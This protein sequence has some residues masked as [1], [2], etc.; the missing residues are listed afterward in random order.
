MKLSEVASKKVRKTVE[1]KQ[2]R[3]NAG[4]KKRKIRKNTI[5]KYKKKKKKIHQS[6]FDNPA[7]KLSSP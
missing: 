4:T 7:R 1:T 6:P 2:E 5:E 3:T